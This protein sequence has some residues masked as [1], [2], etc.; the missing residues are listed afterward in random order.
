[1]PMIIA[2]SFMAA[3][4]LIGTWLRANVPI[5]RTALIPA[6]LIGG[7]IGFILISAGLSLGFEA[8]TFAPFTFHFFTLSFMSLV[9]T[10]SSNVS[11]KSS[12]IYRGGMWLTLIWTMS[13]AMQALIGFSVIAGYNGISGSSISGFLGAI[14]T[15][16][17]TM[18]PGQALTYG[19]IWE[20]SF[21]ISDA[22]TV[23]LIYASFGFIAAF[24]VGVP[25]A[26]WA[27][28]HG[29]NRNATAKIDDEFLRGYYNRETRVSA[30]EQVTHSANVDTLAFHIA[31]LGV[32][33][34]ITNYW[35]V[36]M[37]SIIGDS[38]PLG[39]A[40]GV[41]FSHNLFFFWGLV[42][43]VII[44]ATM[45]RLGISHFIDNDTQKRITGS[46]V[47]FMVVGTIMSIKFAVLVEFLAPV[48]LVTVAVT[49]ATAALWLGLGRKLADL[50]IERSV[51]IFGCCCG[52]TGTGLLLL[53]IL[54][55]DF[56]TSVA[57]E[58]AFFNIAI[59]FTCFHI[60]LV[61]SPILPN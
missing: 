8:R 43:C 57:K 5:F 48:L 50:G 4:L 30:G 58:L 31:I 2:F 24:V 56:S 44:R 7:V 20:K 28:K 19:G 16:G 1:F 23:G 21:N 60:I 27:I 12:P 59:L 36:L 52:S 18:G 51:T 41:I 42:F 37:Q 40:V 38:R 22:A 14:S 15:Y 25:V 39:V 17:Y 53:R 11:D 55:P 9:L 6:S 13:L 10:G 32:A 29:Y 35:L 47:D 46:A 34:I 61:M 3:M 49:L 26:R 33:Y 45:E 54:D